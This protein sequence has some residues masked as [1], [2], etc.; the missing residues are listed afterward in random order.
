MLE[1][2]KQQQEEGVSPAAAV[3]PPVLQRIKT[4]ADTSGEASVPLVK[5]L[6]NCCTLD[7]EEAVLAKAHLVAWECAARSG[8]AS[9]S[10]HLDQPLREALTAND[11][12]HARQILSGRP[13]AAALAGPD[14]GVIHS[15]AWS[16]RDEILALLLDHE[17]V[18]IEFVRRAD[19][20]TA[21][22]IAA[23]AGKASTVRLL[24]ARG[25]SHAVTA[26]RIQATP[27]SVTVQE[28]YHDCVLALLDGGADVSAT[29][30][31][32]ATPL[33]VASAKGHDSIVRLLLAR[34][35]SIEQPR[36]PTGATPL[37][38]ACFEGHEMCARV[39]LEHGAV[40]DAA[41]IDSRS[42][43][44][45]RGDFALYMLGGPVGRQSDAPSC[46]APLR[47]PIAKLLLEHRAT[48]DK[49]FRSFTPLVRALEQA[50][51]QGRLGLVAL[52]LEHGADANQRVGENDAPPIYYA[53]KAGC[54]EN[55][56]LLL[57]HGA[58]VDDV[59]KGGEFGLF[60]AS[61]NGHAAIVEMLLA[62]GAAVDRANHKGYTA[63]H[64]A[65]A[66]AT[67]HG[68]LAV[69]RQLMAQGAAVGCAAANG[70]TPLCCA[71]RGKT[72][73]EGVEVA[74]LLISEGAVDVNEPREHADQPPPLF[75]A[76]REGKLE[77]AELL[78]AEGAA[79]DIVKQASGSTPLHA[80]SNGGFEAMVRLFIERGAAV[81][82]VNQ[83]NVTPLMSACS[84]PQERLGSTAADGV[85]RLL[86]EH[87]ADP[88]RVD[89]YGETALFF[90]VENG[91]EAS[92]RLL[93]ERSTV[94][95]A[96]QSKLTGYVP[97]ML[98]VV[99]ARESM[100]GLLLEYGADADGPSPNGS[101]PLWMARSMLQAASQGDRPASELLRRHRTIEAALTTAGA[102]RDT[103]ILP[104]N[105]IL[106]NGFNT[107]GCPTLSS[108]AG[109][110]YCEVTMHAMVDGCC[111]QFGWAVADNGR[112]QPGDGNGVGDDVY[113]WAADGER[114]KLWHQGGESDFCGVTWRVGDVIGL[115]ADM[116][117]RTLWFGKN[118]S[119]TI[120]FEG[121]EWP[122]GGS[123]GLFPAFS[124]Q[125]VQLEL[126]VG[127]TPLAFSG[128]DA[129]FQPLLSRQPEPVTANLYLVQQLGRCAE[130]PP[131][132]SKYNKPFDVFVAGGGTS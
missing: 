77:I 26:T 109:K 67:A 30:S 124:A 128:P 43:E 65:S 53:C 83:S 131:R 27:L 22:W 104:P 126:N 51:S 129:D 99:E 48:V 100:V 70:E 18:S 114:T 16:G 20:A 84:I 89:R 8:S 85:V 107:V 121:I 90:A 60:E 118:G 35:A 101:T 88:A 63:L 108:S 95:L 31:D 44:H 41:N 112:F 21:L 111:P 57:Q 68:H 56:V 7:S 80:A 34:G 116:A 32:G 39:L 117:S 42:G 2:Q 55:L 86:L 103:P 19:G 47:K 122:G 3:A 79:L 98:A 97:L 9:V 74:K 23:S 45:G 105:H 37:F 15:A 66:C 106:I 81:D 59:W 120:G 62:R 76:A 36:T 1:E 12:E 24:L 71:A 61:I 25:A 92:A 130:D 125:H 73:N 72:R 13:Q 102:V 119:W 28:G 14:P 93:L 132:S 127:A 78:L 17:Y 10:R 110:V 5:M 58:Q 94:P 123:G 50:D 6:E 33:Y 64:A 113:S 38:I 87:A 40:P 69:V 11:P 91:A 52:L 75:V 49:M 29:N 82:A 115:A 54:A 4:F 96:C 46:K